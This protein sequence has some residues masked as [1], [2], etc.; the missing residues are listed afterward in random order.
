MT[1]VARF[2]GQTMQSFGEGESRGR[3]CLLL[4]VLEKIHFMQISR[5]G[6]NEGGRSLNR[7]GIAE[8]DSGRAD[9]ERERE[10]E[11]EIIY[12]RVKKIMK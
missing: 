1:S 2:A 7:A 4:I 10:R 12:Y 3:W 9:G 8:R 5:V 6:L 11:R